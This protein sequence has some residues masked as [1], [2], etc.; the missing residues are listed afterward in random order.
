VNE[1]LREHTTSIGFSLTLT[2]AQISALVLCHHT[3]GEM[4]HN[5]PAVKNF[6]VTMGCLRDRGLITWATPIYHKT[7]MGLNGAPVITGWKPFR[8]T[9]AGTLVV[10]L[11][12]EAGIYQERLADMGMMQETKAA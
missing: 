10:N 11:L 1:A 9:K 8:T 5:T 2:K 6:V 4:P 3:K 7:R 12:K